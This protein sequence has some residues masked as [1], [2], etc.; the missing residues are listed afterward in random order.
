M[1]GSTLD[2]DEVIDRLL[3]QLETLINFK[4]ASLQLIQDDR[5]ELIGGR[6][7]DLEE[8][9]EAG[10]LLMPVSQDPL[11]R[12]AVEAKEPVIIPDVV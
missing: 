2:L 11:I 7:F 4:T 10:G 1:V 6:G 9:K 3:D 8:A 12:E 5:R